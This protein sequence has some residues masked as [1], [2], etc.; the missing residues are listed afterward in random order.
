MAIED[1]KE[2]LEVPDIYYVKVWRKVPGSYEVWVEEI[3]EKT[4]AQSSLGAMQ[5]IVDAQT[6]KVMLENKRGTEPEAPEHRPSLRVRI[7]VKDVEGEPLGAN[8][9]ETQ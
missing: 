1:P 7:G 3:N 9:T 2:G 4:S 5:S 8:D 6:A